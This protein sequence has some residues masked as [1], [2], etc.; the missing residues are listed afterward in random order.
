MEFYSVDIE[1][2]IAGWNT[3]YISAAGEYMTPFLV[4]S[5][6]MMQCTESSKLKVLN[7]ARFDSEARARILYKLITCC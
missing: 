3:P 2:L 7:G 5:K 6:G 4:C 1:M